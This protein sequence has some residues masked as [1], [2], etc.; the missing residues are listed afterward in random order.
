MDK[1]KSHRE[2]LKKLFFA[3]IDRDLDKWTENIFVTKLDESYSSKN[4]DNSVSFLIVEP[5][6]K[7]V[8]GKIYLKIDNVDI[9]EFLCVYKILFIPLD[10]KV[11]KYV[12]KLKKHFRQKKI[13]KKNEEH[14]YYLEKGIKTLESDFLQEFRKQKLENL[15]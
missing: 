6:Q 15:K 2:Q 10:F 9:Y 8:Y 7:H 13:D 3:S 4:Y 12:K 11:C 5:H 1:L 14:I